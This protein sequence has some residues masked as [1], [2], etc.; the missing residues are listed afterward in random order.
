MVQPVIWI[1]AMLRDVSPTGDFQV[2]FVPQAAV[3]MREAF[4]GAVDVFRLVQANANQNILAGIRQRVFDWALSLTERGVAL[5]DDVS[6]DE[7]FD[8]P[9]EPITG[10]AAARKPASRKRMKEFES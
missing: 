4:Q 7:F 6:F 8:R 1:E 10:D 9:P 2:T 5:P 3:Q